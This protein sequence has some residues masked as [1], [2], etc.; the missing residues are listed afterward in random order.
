MFTFR[1]LS[2][3]LHKRQGSTEI[4]LAITPPKQGEHVGCWECEA[5]MPTLPTMVVAE[6]HCATPPGLMVIVFATCGQRC[7][8]RVIAEAQGG[9]HPARILDDAEAAEVIAQWPNLT[10]LAAQRVPGGYLGCIGKLPIPPS[11]GSRE[12]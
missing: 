8:D 10:I 5:A 3:P 12:H 9:G 1:N 7:A 2:Q 4:V 6:A 11:G